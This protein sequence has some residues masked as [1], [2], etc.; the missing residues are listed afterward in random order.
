MRWQDTSIYYDRNEHT[1]VEVRSESNGFTLYF[2][3]NFDKNQ[4]FSKMWDYY[5]TVT[6]VSYEKLKLAILNPTRVK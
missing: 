3:S 6:G 2:Y 1:M 5:I 4:T